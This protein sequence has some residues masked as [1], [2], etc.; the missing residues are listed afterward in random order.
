MRNFWSRY[1]EEV[2]ALLWGIAVLI[3]GGAA[4]LV[5]WR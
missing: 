5:P 3:A 1:S 4:L 2:G